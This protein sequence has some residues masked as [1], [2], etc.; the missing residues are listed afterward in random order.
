MRNALL[1]RR[2]CAAAVALVCLTLLFSL[3]AARAFAQDAAPTYLP[4][5]G[6]ADSQWFEQLTSEQRQA[7]VATVAAGRSASGEVTLPGL[8]TWEKDFAKAFRRGE[9]EV[10][11]DAYALESWRYQM[12]RLRQ[13]AGVLPTMSSSQYFQG[14]IGDGFVYRKQNGALVSQYLGIRMGNGSDTLYTKL[15]LPAP[16]PSTTDEDWSWSY[17]GGGL[18][19]GVT[20]PSKP[21]FQW[22]VRDGCGYHTTYVYGTDYGCWDIANPPPTRYSGNA[23]PGGNWSASW[24]GIDD[25]RPVGNVGSSTTPAGWG[26]TKSGDGFT[27]LSYA[28]P[29]AP[30]A[31][32]IEAA[33]ASYL[34]SGEG[35]F[36]RA[37]LDWAFGVVGTGPVPESLDPSAADGPMP[38][39]LPSD[40]LNAVK[41]ASYYTTTDALCSA[42]LT[43]PGTNTM[44]PPST[45]TDQYRTCETASAGGKTPLAA[46][47]L[48]LATVAAG[49]GSITWYLL[50]HSD[51]PQ[52]APFSAPPPPS[53]RP[54]PFAPLGWPDTSTLAQELKSR[55]GNLNLTQEQAA[56]VANDCVY[57][58]GRAAANGLEKCNTLPIFVTGSTTEEAAK[59][60]IRALGSRESWALLNYE[61]A[62][63]KET[64][65][66][67][68]R[69]YEAAEFNCSRHPSMPA[70]QEPLQC[71]EYPLYA[72]QQG[73]KFAALTPHL[74]KIDADDNEFQGTVFGVFVRSY[75]CDLQTGS[76][77]PTQPMANAGGGSPFIALPIL[78]APPVP[79]VPTGYICAR[80]GS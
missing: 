55:P 2:L 35:A 54:K 75:A 10:A 39:D 5:T 29:P 48:I 24:L 22:G 68:R 38:T 6:Q 7:A 8:S 79:P 34:E 51:D 43:Y 63:G 9:S 28:M 36:S 72:T 25:M 64:I 14:V 49:G 57:Y 31:S 47:K 46:L 23:V 41:I 58:V 69:W 50:T 42:L 73:G 52:T 18:G 40:D 65:Q 11:P 44:Q 59:H 32:Q 4:V 13:L 76:N 60:D 77:P 12:F 74:E 70:T 20:V 19:S 66:H 37:V 78:T 33:I 3:S 62:T 21:G 27:F 67:N 16:L 17:E 56:E 80:S 30:S 53:Q 61:Y 71:D 26:E 1:R 45:L 15:E